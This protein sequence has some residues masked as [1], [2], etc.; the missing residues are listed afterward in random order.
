MRDSAEFKATGG[1]GLYRELLSNAVRHKNRL[2]ALIE[3]LTGRKPHQLDAEVVS[4][5]MLGLV[6]M[7]PGSKVE[8][9]AAV[10]ESVGLLAWVGKPYLKG[11]INA[12]LRR[13]QREGVELEGALENRALQ[14]SHPEWM[15]KKW[16]AVF[17]PEVM[18]QLAL[19][20]N[21]PPRIWLVPRP[22]LGVDGL[23]ERL[24]AQGITCEVEGGALW[25]P[26]AAGLFETPAYQEGLFYVQDPSAQAIAAWAASLQPKRLLDACAA[27]GG[28]L[29]YL[30]WALPE[31]DAVAL[32]PNAGRMK[33]TREN[34]KR[35][36][37]KA[38]LSETTAEDFD[39]ALGFDLVLADVP[40]SATGTIGKHPEIKW[41]RRPADFARNQETQGILLES[42]AP[43]VRSGGHLLY[44]TCSLEAEE[45]EAVV[46]DF[47]AGH[48]QFSRQVTPEGQPYLRQLPQPGRSGSF[49][50]LL[51][52]AETKKTA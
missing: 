30:L 2:M 7:S 18:M 28:K 42:L 27:P 44:A 47:L 37:L 6:Q 4:A 1:A 51:V 20:H 8:P 15:L 5:L 9:W 10:D 25:V 22:D 45:N 39:D 31:L 50:A 17:G 34:L 49:G 23:K 36:G 16:E 19:A 35:L 11:V 33:R 26:K 43:L 41:D 3:T 13:Y 29:A 46:E 38:R 12:S 32:E 48:P 21:Q 40:C 14:L 52:K 24:A